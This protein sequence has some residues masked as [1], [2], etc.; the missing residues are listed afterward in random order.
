MMRFRYLE[1]PVFLDSGFEDKEF[2]YFYSLGTNIA[3]SGRYFIN[4]YCG[5]GKSS[6]YI[7]EIQTSQKESYS[8]SGV[9]FDFEAGMDFNPMFLSFSH[10]VFLTKTVDNDLNYYILWPFNYYLIKIGVKW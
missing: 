1:R 3:T 2:G 10:S 5:Y 6:G 7:K 9:S 8:F 4:T